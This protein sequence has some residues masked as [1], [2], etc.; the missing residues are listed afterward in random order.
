MNAD[1]TM[2]VPKEIQDMA[3]K[4]ENYFVM[5]GVYKWEL[6][7]VCSRS[8]VNDMLLLEETLRRIREVVNNGEL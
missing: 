7:G 3:I 2:S 4:I 1:Y 8:H 6:M 5:Q